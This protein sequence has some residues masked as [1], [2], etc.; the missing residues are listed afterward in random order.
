[1]KTGYFLFGGLPMPTFS[2]VDMFKKY[3]EDITRMSLNDVEEYLKEGNLRRAI[4]CL[5]CSIDVCGPAEAF[6]RKMEELLEEAK[7]VGLDLNE[8]KKKPSRKVKPT[9]T[10]QTTVNQTRNRWQP[11]VPRKTRRS[12]FSVVKI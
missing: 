3:E 4:S 5:Q 8:K 7:R 11:R 1:M 12:R 9:N 2:T 6:T 10:G